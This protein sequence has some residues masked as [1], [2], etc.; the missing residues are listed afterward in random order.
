MAVKKKYYAVRKGHEV[1]IFLTWA[2]CQKATKGFSGAEFKS[3]KTKEEATLYMEGGKEEILTL[4]DDEVVRAYVDGSY[5]HS[6][7]MYAGGAVILFKGEEHYIS[8]SNNIEEMATMRNVAGELL[9]AV[10]AMEWFDENGLAQ[11]AKKLVIY[12]DYEGIAKW[13]TGAWQAKKEGT[14]AYVGIFNEF[15]EKFPIEFIKVAAHTGDKY[16]EM[17]DQLAKKALGLL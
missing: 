10:R 16:N 8:E 6:I 4:P 17:A 11:G 1:G 9:G 12:H 7:K 2:A 15:R 5:D 13:A 3:F 14:K